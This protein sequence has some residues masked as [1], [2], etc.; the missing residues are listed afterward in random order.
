MVEFIKKHKVP[1]I[2]LTVIVV[3]YLLYDYFNAKAAAA[4]AAAT[5]NPMGGTTAQ[6]QQAYDNA[7]SA[8]QAGATDTGGST[9]SPIA[10]SPAVT[11]TIP[12]TSTAPISTGTVSN[13]VGSTGTSVG[14]TSANPSVPVVTPGSGVAGA[15]PVPVLNSGYGAT[16]P[17]NLG[18]PIGA[19]TVSQEQAI[20]SS[21]NAALGS[22]SANADLAIY[23]GIESGNPADIALENS[24]NAIFTEQDPQQA[25]LAEKAGSNPYLQML[26]QGVAGPE[27]PNSTLVA[28]G[29]NPNPA[30]FQYPTTESANTSESSGGQGTTAGAGG[31]T[32][33][34][35]TSLSLTDPNAPATI[36]APVGGP[37]SLTASSGIPNPTRVLT[38]VPASPKNNIGTSPSGGSGSPTGATNLPNSPSNPA[39]PYAPVRSPVATGPVGPGG[40]SVKPIA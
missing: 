20:N 34:I 17:T 2:I 38:T 18:V 13:P 22:S 6:Q 7:L 31:S 39:I 26:S 25:A 16:G 32:S 8:L 23:Q 21:E 5:P 29:F 19:D 4:A 1:F 10:S 30:I 35:G 24:Y 27:I 12:S 33:A 40:T 36:T 3:S 11:G 14:S 9:G 37:S 28:E 15:T